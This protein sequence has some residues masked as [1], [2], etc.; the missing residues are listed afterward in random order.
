[1]S[2]VLN[3]CRKAL[4]GFRSVNHDL[5]ESAGRIISLKDR[6]KS[7][8]NELSNGHPQNRPVDKYRASQWKQREE[9]RSLQILKCL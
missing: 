5:L 4:F 1:M 3:I 8:N 9:L 2:V 7:V 6:G